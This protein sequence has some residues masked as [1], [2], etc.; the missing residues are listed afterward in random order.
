MAMSEIRVNRI[1]KPLRKLSEQS[2]LYHD[3]FFD[4]AEAYLMV[5]ALFYKLMTPNEVHILA[6]LWNLRNILEM[7]N[8]LETGGWFYCTSMRLETAMGFSRQVQHR[9]IRKLIGRG[10]LKTQRRG[11]PSK[12]WVRLNRKRIIAAATAERNKG[13]EID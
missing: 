1:G 11:I 6:Y 2:Q 5:P 13:L 3:F 4:H 7:S 12:R 10:F 9:I 8:Q